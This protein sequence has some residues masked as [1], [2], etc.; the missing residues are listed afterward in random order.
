MVAFVNDAFGETFLEPW[1]CRQQSVRVDEVDR[2]DLSGSTGCPERLASC[3]GKT[4]PDRAM[5]LASGIKERL[6]KRRRWRVEDGGKSRPLAPGDIAILCATN[7]RCLSLAGALASFG[8]KVAL[9]RGGLFGTPEAQL[10]FA[11]LRWCADQRD[12]LALAEMAHLLHV[13]DGQPEWFEASLEDGGH[14]ALAALVPMA[15]R[16]SRHRAS[17]AR[18]KA[19]RNS[20]TPC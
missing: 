16:S 11:A 4:I 14:E 3:K 17:R 10:A 18:T 7:D 15:R 19:R 1:A 8:L 20:P 13:G 6:A 5:A 9:E 2:A 12:T